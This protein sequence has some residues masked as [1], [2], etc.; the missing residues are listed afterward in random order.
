MKIYRHRAVNRIIYDSFEVVVFL[1][2]NRTHLMDQDFWHTRWNNN[3]IGFHEHNGNALLKRFFKK[4]KLN[5]GD[6]V[7]VPLCGK[8]K[9]IPWLLLHK[10]NVVG[11]ELNES[12]V[13]QLFQE[14]NI[15]PSISSIDDFKLYETENLKI[16]VGD[17]FKLSQPILGRLDAIY[18]RGAL[19]ALPSTMRKDYCNKLRAMAPNAE[20]LTISFSYPQEQFKGPPFSVT[21]DEINSHFGRYYTI[22]VLYHSL[23]KEP[24]RGFDNVYESAYM[25]SPKAC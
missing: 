11:I 16:Y 3:E 5:Q 14:M 12:A 20:Q 18:D 21:E 25:L 1:I 2:T 13:I 22:S 19:V 4:L 7:F 24:F 6:T 23:L 9:D 10:F 8:T 17:F 15:E